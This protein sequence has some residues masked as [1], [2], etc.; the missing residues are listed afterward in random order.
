MAD[1]ARVSFAAEQVIG[2]IKTDKTLGVFGGTIQLGCVIDLDDVIERCVHDEQRFAQRA[3]GLFQTLFAEILN[4][5]TFHQERTPTQVNLGLAARLQGL[6]G[7]REQLQHVRG[8][9]RRADRCN[10]DGRGH[11][12]RRL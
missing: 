4:E 1:I 11:L 9:E 6:L 8:I 7:A 12:R 10:C 5:L 2:F 3:H